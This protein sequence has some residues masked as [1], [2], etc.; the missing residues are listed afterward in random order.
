MGIKNGL[1]NGTIDIL[2]T[3]TVIFDV[4]T[5]TRILISEFS[6]DPTAA[7]SVSFYRSPDLTSA[8]GKRLGDVSFSIDG[9]VDIGFLIGQGF[10][11]GQNIIAIAVATGVNATMTYAL[12]DGDSV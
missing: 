5:A 10:S 9:T 1:S 6:C 3:D 8:S 12:F 7:T 4:A 2:A 11:F